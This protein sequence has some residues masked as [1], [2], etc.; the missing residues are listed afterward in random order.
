MGNTSLFS[1]P[2]NAV[3]QEAYANVITYT[4]T[5]KS[6]ETA[7]EAYKNSRKYINTWDSLITLPDYNRFLKREPGV[8]CGLVV[9]CQKVLEFFCIRLSLNL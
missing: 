6:P 9:D 2:N 4:V 8:D 5:G 1:M 7:S 3:T